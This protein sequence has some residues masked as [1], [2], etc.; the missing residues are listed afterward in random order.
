[1]AGQGVLFASH[2]KEL[3]RE[4]DENS[5]SYTLDN[6]G[7]D[8]SAGTDS[9]LILW[10]GVMSVVLVFTLVLALRK[11]RERVVRVV[12]KYSR[13]L[14]RPS[15]PKRSGG[16]ML[17]AGFSK[18]GHPLRVR[19]SADSLKS[20]KTGVSVGRE[21]ALVDIAAADGRISRRHARFSV[22]G[23]VVYVEDLNSANG[24][25]LNGVRL[26]PFERKAVKAGDTLVLG[27]VEF[28]VSSD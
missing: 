5:V 3:I 13:K 17:L 26:K 21:P 7:C 28:S 10:I 11:P 1:M 6:S 20:A 12:E 16:G 27:G 8:T 18:T 15:M 24:T 9:R 2:I 25:L 19:L 14:S 23:G 4:L 22:S